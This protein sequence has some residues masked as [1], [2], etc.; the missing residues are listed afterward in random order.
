MFLY[1]VLVLDSI[2]YRNKY[3]HPE[4]V[5]ILSLVTYHIGK[6]SQYLKENIVIDSKQPQ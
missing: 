6:K 3:E 4:C 5:L 2:N 1:I